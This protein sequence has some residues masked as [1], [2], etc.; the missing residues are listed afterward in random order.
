M[1]K[2]FRTLHAN[3]RA[4]NAAD[5]TD[6]LLAVASTAAYG[7]L[8]GRQTGGAAANETSVS[9]MG[10]LTTGGGGAG[11]GNNATT[12]SGNNRSPSAAGTARRAIGSSISSAAVGGTP[13]R[14]PRSSILGAPRG[15]A[16]PTGTSLRPPAASV[17]FASNA[18]SKIHS[19]GANGAWKEM[20][21]PLGLPGRQ[22]NGASVSAE[23]KDSRKCVLVVELLDAL[24]ALLNSAE[25]RR[26]VRWECFS[27]LAAE[28][29]GYIHK[30]QLVL[31]RRHVY[32]N[33][34]ASEATAAVT[35]SMVRALEDAFSVV[36]AEEEAAYVKAN[37]KGR[38][39]AAAGGNLSANQKSAIPLH[40]MRKS[41]MDFSL[42]CRF[43]DELPQMPAAFM[44][45]WLPLLMDGVRQQSS[46]S[47]AAATGDGE[48]EENSGSSAV[49]A[50]PIESTAARVAEGVEN[51]ED[52]SP[53][54]VRDG[55]GKA[56][57]A[58]VHYATRKPGS[59]GDEE[60]FPLELLGS[61]PAAR[62]AAV[63]QLL[64]RRMEQL[65]DACDALDKEKLHRETST[66][67]ETFGN[68]DAAAS[69]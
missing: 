9:Y 50:L 22:L 62:Q 5:A 42:F 10:A 11:P 27:V 39:G 16:S 13:N 54:S 43:F 18:L 64:M 37:K 69:V 17:S 53:S 14:G 57:A 33:G 41:H 1:Q 4:H 29:R 28:G 52:V 6:I 8:S 7:G 51:A 63:Q 60:G 55:V 31:L 66:G 19:P 65:Q 3:T 15:P 32:R 67:N 34:S 23:L 56:T 40:M 36:A 38:K 49:K 59:A 48:D 47:S 30:S 44:H 24:D 61:T 21:S 20:G 45:V 2:L 26:V 35:A 25:T 46:A 12:R 68:P 58:A